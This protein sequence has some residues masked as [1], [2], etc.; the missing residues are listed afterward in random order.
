M[1]KKINAKG[2]YIM[3]VAINVLKAL[4]LVLTSVCGIIFGIFAP[5]AI[6]F[7]DIVDAAISEHYIIK[8]WLINSIVCYIAGTVLLMLNLYKTAS[9]F[10]FVG[11]IVSV[12]IYGVFQGL[13]EGQDATNP[14]GLYM[15]IMFVTILTFITTVLANKKVIE[16]RLS[17]K[18]EKEHEAAPSILGGTYQYKEADTQKKR[19][20]K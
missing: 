8:I 1:I 4:I 5:L 20:R 12:F 10:H 6:M 16:E 11:L 14:A 3:K 15:P 13:Y 2:I 17:K 18:K 19:G 9:C 7:G